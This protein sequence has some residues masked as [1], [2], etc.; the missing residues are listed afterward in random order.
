MYL[1]LSNANCATVSAPLLEPEVGE[2]TFALEQEYIFGRDMKSED[3]KSVVP[4]VVGDPVTGDLNLFGT[5]DYKIKDLG[6]TMF[7]ARYQL[8]DMLNVYGKV[9]ITAGGDLVTGSNNGTWAKNNHPAVS[10]N[11]GTYETITNRDEDNALAA[12]LGFKLLFP[13][14]NCSILGVDAQYLTHK[15]NYNRTVSENV[16]DNT[17]NPVSVYSNYNSQTNVGRATVSEWHIAPFVAKSLGNIVYYTGFK[18]SDMKVKL[19]EDNLTLSAKHNIGAFLGADYKVSDIISLNIEGRFIDET[20]V[21]VGGVLYFGQLFPCAGINVEPYVEAPPAPVVVSTPVV[22]TAPKVDLEASKI[23]FQLAKYDVR[24]EDIA[25]LKRIVELIKETKPK[26]VKIEGFT[27][28]IGKDEYNVQL[29]QKR[30]ESAKAF[31]V[32]EGIPTDIIETV[33]YGSML[34]LANNESESGRLENRRV[35]FVFTYPNGDI[36]RPNMN[37]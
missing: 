25:G 6:R 20:A 28:S 26:T 27:D 10:E 31:I 9:G 29:S 23:K 17:G 1:G 3:F 22:V 16:Y 19:D 5:V 35:E 12:A 11:F 33:G 15:S 34:P 2:F 24:Q 21:T 36:V 7:S 13:F 32:S 8:C 30:A 18:Y 4:F 14:V 37:K